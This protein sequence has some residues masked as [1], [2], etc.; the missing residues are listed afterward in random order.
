[1]TMIRDMLKAEIEQRGYR[2]LETDARQGAECICVYLCG[3]HYLDVLFK[4]GWIKFTHI[5]TAYSAKEPRR[6]VD[7]L[8]NIADPDFSEENVVD[9]IEWIIKGI[10]TRIPDWEE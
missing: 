8:F 5:N 7:E 1:M 3:T 2:T 10:K 6:E 9:T 4:D